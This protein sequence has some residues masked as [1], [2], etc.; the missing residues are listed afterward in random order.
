MP[1]AAPHRA[2]WL[3]VILLAAAIVCSHPIWLRWAGAALV[4]NEPPMP[5]DV[6]VVLAGGWRGNRILRA[7]ELVR[8]GWAPRVLVSGT[9]YYGWSEPDAAIDF[10][11]RHG[12]PRDWFVALPHGAQSTEEEARIV[13]DRLRAM[14]VKRVLLVTSDYHTRRAAGCFR[15]VAPELELRAIAAA[16]PD[17]PERW[18][19]SRQGRKTFLLEWLKMLSWRLGM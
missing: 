3:I 19:Q 2:R 16:D 5:A 6:A 13:T 4:R 12:Y 9:Q 11:V 15:Q 14:G 7:A 17:F 10:A 8:Q 1:P 18:W